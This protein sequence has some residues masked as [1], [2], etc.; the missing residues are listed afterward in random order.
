MPS[1]D[2]K[3]FKLGSHFSGDKG[4]GRGRILLKRN[5]ANVTN[6]FLVCFAVDLVG[7]HNHKKGICEKA[8]SPAALTQLPLGLFPA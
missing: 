5:L 4:L 2:H 3:M 8:G 7:P 1:K 6:L